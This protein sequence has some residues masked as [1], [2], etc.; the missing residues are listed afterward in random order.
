MQVFPR[1]VF[2]LDDG[3]LDMK[4]ANFLPNV[5]LNVLIA[6]TS[7]PEVTKEDTIDN[8]D[9]HDMDGIAES[10]SDDELVSNLHTIL[11]SSYLSPCN[12]TL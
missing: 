10:D 11:S 9:E 3:A 7:P 1:R 5:S 6:P 4:E 8:T 2:T 12:R